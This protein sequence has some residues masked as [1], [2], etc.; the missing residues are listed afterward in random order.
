MKERLKPGFTASGLG[1][2]I[3]DKSRPFKVVGSTESLFD[4][5]CFLRPLKFSFEKFVLLL[6]TLA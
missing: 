1:W 6:P 3:W 2:V 4:S 5:A